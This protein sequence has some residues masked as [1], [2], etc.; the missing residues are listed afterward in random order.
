VSVLIR[1]SPKRKELLERFIVLETVTVGPSRACN[2]RIK[3]TITHNIKTTEANIRNAEETN[4][5][6]NYTFEQ[7]R[8]KY[9]FMEEFF[10]YYFFSCDEQEVNSIHGVPFP[11]FENV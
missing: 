5:E 10:Y 8:P 11:G 6:Q 1:H 3:S 7:K 9:L 4:T 2:I